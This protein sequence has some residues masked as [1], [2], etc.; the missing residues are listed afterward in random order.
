LSN[1]YVYSPAG[2]LIS[3]GD[4]KIPLSNPKEMSIGLK[5]PGDGVYVVQWKTVSAD[6]GDPDQGAFVFTVKANAVA[7][8]PTVASAKPAATT[9]TSSD[10]GFP[11]GP[12]V[13]VGSI[14]LLLGL[15]V[16]FGIGRNR[17]ASVPANVPS[18][19]VPEEEEASSRKP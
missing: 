19:S 16:G 8:T 12:V 1:L 14:A 15:G 2:D 18:A 10:S 11:V 5:P 6:D 4:A 13:L 17:P 7:A 9:A 3:Q